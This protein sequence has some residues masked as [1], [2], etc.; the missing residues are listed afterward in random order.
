[1]FSAL[2]PYIHEL[3]KKIKKIAVVFILFF[4]GTFFEAGRIITKL[5][6]IFNLKDVTIITTSPF[7]LLSLSTTIATIVGG[8]AALVVFIYSL[9]AFL[10][11]GL[12]KNERRL[13]LLLVVSGIFLFCI[14]VLYGF[15]I[16]YFYLI[17]VSKVNLTLGIENAW[18]ITSFFSQMIMTALVLGFVF[19]F[20]IFLTFLIRTG[21]FDTRYLRK[22]RGMAYIIILVFV[23]FLPPPDIF[24]TFIEAL[25]LILLFELVLLVNRPRRSSVVEEPLLEE[26]E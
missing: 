18:D 21:K 25:P 9:Y 22:K 7:Q 20:P 14:G 5:L 26:Y 4:L 1:M 15:A 3:R 19:Q 23:G 8:A 10:R 2:T 12:R 16:L 6:H 24:S 17:S 11:D 13:F